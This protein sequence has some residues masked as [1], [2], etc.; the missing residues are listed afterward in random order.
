VLER[1]GDALAAIPSPPR[2]FI[3]NRLAHLPGDSDQAPAAH[4]A[5]TA[6]EQADADREIASIPFTSGTTLAPKGVL[7][8]HR[9]FLSNVRSLLAVVHFTSSDDLLSVLPMHHLLEFTGGFLA[10]LSVG[11]TVTYA[12]KLTPKVLLETMQ[13]TETSVLIGVPR[14]LMLLTRALRARSDSS[15]PGRRRAL[16]LLL[17]LASLCDGIARL[18]PPLRRL[19]AVLFRAAHKRLG[20]RMRIVVSGGAALPPDVYRVLDV[21]GFTVCE[22]YGL[23]ETSPVLTVN[24]PGRPRCGTVGPAIPGVELRIT[25]PNADGIGEVL[26]RGA[27]VFS[28]YLDD[29]QATRQAF[30]GEWFCTG[31]LGSLDQDGYLVLA[32]RADDVI[33]TGGGKNVHPVEVEW[34]YRDLPHVKELCVIGVP[35]RATAGDAVHAVVVLDEPGDLQPLDARKREVEAAVS[36]ISRRLPTHQR[37]RRLHFW[38][39]ELPRTNTLKVKRRQLRDAVRVQ[40]GAH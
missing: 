38:E 6:S 40:A 16:A 37:I 30:R 2:V 19:R 35:D 22:G 34:L 14:L 36:E 23:T 26:A 7:L 29:E 24:P 28:G 18:G 10:P 27:C 20:G 3:V 33:V 21:M 39:G 11:A 8:T 25:D 17:G 4:T 12:E 13:S 15:S 1:I 32:G 31:D 5:E 9:N